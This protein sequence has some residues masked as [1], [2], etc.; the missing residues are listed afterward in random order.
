MNDKTKKE[1]ETLCNNTDYF[2]NK[3]REI[4]VKE[5]EN[6]SEPEEVVRLGKVGTHIDNIRFITNC[7]RNEVNKRIIQWQEFLT[8]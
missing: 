8:Q 2:A 6:I 3:I 4:I 1:I 7:I 5:L